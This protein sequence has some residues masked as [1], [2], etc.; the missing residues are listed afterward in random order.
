MDGG[1]H[2]FRFGG[3]NGGR[4]QKP[5]FFLGLL[6]EPFLLHELYG[7]GYVAGKPIEERNFF[8]VEIVRLSGKE[9]E[10]RY[11]AI[12]YADWERRRRTVAEP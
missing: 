5:H 11:D 12:L 7:V 2:I 4:L 6:S 1:F 8:F 10:C 3:G 9:V